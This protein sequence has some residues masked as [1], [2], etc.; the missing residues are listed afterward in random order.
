MNETYESLCAASPTERVLLLS[1]CLR[2]SQDCPGTFRKEGLVCPESCDVDCV[3]GRL[4]TAAL[5][6]GYKGVCIA[7]G[8]A[9]ALRFVAQHDPRGIVAVACEK[10]LTE[11]VDA[12][13]SSVGD[14]KTPP[15]VTVVPLIRDGCVDTEV[16]EA[17]AMQAIAAGCCPSLGE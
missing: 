13:R 8:G 7:A 17:L 5:S 15:A 1:H 12:V 10:E 2:P 9:M 4:R 14:G 6:L 11:G 16:D 3:V